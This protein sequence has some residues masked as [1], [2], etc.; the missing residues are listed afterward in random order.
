MGLNLLGGLDWLTGADKKMKVS[1]PPPRDYAGEVRNTLK[2][3]QDLFANQQQ[4][5]PQ[6]TQLGLQNQNMALYGNGQTPGI[7][8]QYM[9]A[10]PMLSDA[11]ANAGYSNV[12]QYGAPLAASLRA[13][14][15]QQQALMDEMSRQ[16]LLGLQ[17]QNQL[18]P[19]DIYNT[20]SPMRQ[21]WA[22]R[23]LGRSQPGM[24]S[25]ALQ[26]SRA[27]DGRQQQRQQFAGTTAGMENTF[28][29]A[30]ANSY[31]L[32]AADSGA[33]SG[34]MGMADKIGSAPTNWSQLNPYSSDVFNTNY[35]ADAAARI[36][37]SN[38]QTGMMS[39]M[40]SY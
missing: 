10:L 28:Y 8:D 1:A 30:P 21:D 2:A 33:M 36:A 16:S 32:G 4:Y 23:G 24:L 27:G 6:Y 25:E 15:P 3:S 39:S 13:S 14:N 7:V 34:L 22:N 18:S 38:N 37:T 11:Q 17:A 26:L 35:N 5:S 9:R 29:T 31:A 19:Q 12:N 20:V 40:M